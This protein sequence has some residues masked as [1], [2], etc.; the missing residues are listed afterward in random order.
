MPAQEKKFPKYAVVRDWLTDHIV[1]G[2]LAPG[3]R[4]PT[5]SELVDRFGVS[6]VTVRHALEEL[7]QANL[8][9]SR[10]GYGHFVQECRAELDLRRMLGLQEALDASSKRVATK[11]LDRRVVE[12]KG[13]LRKQLALPRPAEI[14]R[15]IRVR[16]INSTPIC[17]ELRHFPASYVNGLADE[18]FEDG[19]ICTLLETTLGV[20]IAFG[21]V[22]MD[23]VAAPRDVAS[24]LEVAP[25]ST[26]VRTEQ[27]CF[28]IGRRPVEFCIRHAVA[29]AFRYRTRVGR[30]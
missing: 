9:D 3:Q 17:H 7:R 23:I 30:E 29:G 1:G 12:A 21:D 18:E 8:I 25:E 4:L 20:P 14:V 15:L 24:A 2:E 27:L 11:L 13:E 5:E 6:R 26:V 19:D 10:Q 16:S 28:D 22:V